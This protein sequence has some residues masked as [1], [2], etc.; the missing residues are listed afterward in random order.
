MLKYFVIAI[1]LQV[2]WGFTPS[3]SKIILESLP[4][5][6]YIALRFTI[7]A[8]VFL[9]FS[10][11]KYGPVRLPKGTLYKLAPVGIMTYAFSSLGALYGLKLGGVLNFSLASSMNAV[12]TSAVALVLLKEKAH[13]YFKLAALLSVVG[14]VI[15]F[16]GKSG[17]SNF[18]IAAGSLFL[19][20]FS[21]G[22]E[23]VGFAFSKR[24]KDQMPLTVYMAL[25]QLAGSLF[26]WGMVA[27]GTQGGFAK[28]LAMPQMGWLALAYVSLIACC[29]C[30]FV[31]YW[32][33]N[34]IEGHRLAFFDC[35]HTGMSA[36]LGVVLFHDAV[37]NLMIG[38]GILLVASTSLI[39]LPA[40]PKKTKTFEPQ[41]IPDPL[42]Q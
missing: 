21:Y 20:W 19:I 16:V 17:T 6:L 36:L 31:L 2:V 29:A 13:P 10:L 40:S 35:F 23:A 41:K 18:Q 22:F 42:H 8:V 38:G 14:A 33:L 9:L 7:S 26:M 34:H 24:T 30:Y 27:V 28:L 3:A 39:A 5:E 4:V 37:N 32:L 1:L 15:L 11:V 25:V 12:V